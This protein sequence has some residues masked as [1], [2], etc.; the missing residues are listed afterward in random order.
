M[1]RGAKG[2][3][4]GPR[5]EGPIHLARHPGRRPRAPVAR[6][7]A[8]RQG[9]RPRRRGMVGRSPGHGDGPAR[10]RCSSRAGSRPS[11]RSANPTRRSS[12]RSPE[13][14]VA[15]SP[16]RSSGPWPNPAPN[17]TSSC[18]SVARRSRRS[19]SWG[20]SCSARGTSFSP[21]RA[22]SSPRRAPVAGRIG[23]FAR[24]HPT[25]DRPRGR[26]RGR[27]VPRRLRPSWP[28]RGPTSRARLAARLAL[29]GPVAEE[30]IARGGW[31]GSEPAATS[32]SLV[33]P[34]LH[35]IL[36]ELVQEVGDGLGGT[37]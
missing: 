32:A 14:S 21:G 37:S 30:V 20:S 33:T 24:G 25:R 7:G 23:M 29:G 31:Q 13:R 36:T 34:R 12:P 35:A 19:S 11:C 26:T 27:W 3:A 18:S 5:P 1:E 16:A 15:C 17:G 28:V 8:G 2:G 9:I 10:A 6:A 4:G 22:R